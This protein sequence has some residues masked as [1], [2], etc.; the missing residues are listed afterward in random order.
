MEK[1]SRF[2]GKYSFLSNFYPCEVEYEG[3]VYPSVENAFQAAKTAPHRRH[4]FTKISPK[5]AKKMGRKVPLLGGAGHWE[6]KKVKVMEELVRRKFTQ[7]PE[8]RQKLLQTGDAILIE[9]TTWGDEF[10]GVNLKKPDPSS[11][12]G[13]KGKNMLGQIL[14]KVREELRQEV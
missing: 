11:P 3:L 2:K 8:L 13:Y 7:N 6:S 5:E 10:W 4:A 1:I 14:M 9:G 12:W